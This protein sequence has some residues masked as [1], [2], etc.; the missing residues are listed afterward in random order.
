MCAGVVPVLGQ[1]AGCCK[2]RGAISQGAQAGMR[3]FQALST[4]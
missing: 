1:A 2:S 3:G 4:V